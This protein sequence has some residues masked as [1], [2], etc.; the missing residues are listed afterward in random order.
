MN[1]T[2]IML[3]DELGEYHAWECGECG[4]IYMSQ[5][6]AEACCVITAAELEAAGQGRLL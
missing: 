3:V 2:E 5:A 6:N 1:A 4:T